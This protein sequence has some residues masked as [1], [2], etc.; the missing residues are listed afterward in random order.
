[1]PAGT[2]IE[3][4]NGVPVAELATGLVPGRQNFLNTDL[5]D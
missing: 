4:L 2:V 5:V 3:P 1:M